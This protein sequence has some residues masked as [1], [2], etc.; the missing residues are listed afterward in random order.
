MA[1]PD[2]L[3]MSLDAKALKF[4]SEFLGNRA[5]RQIIVFYSMMAENTEFERNYWDN[6]QF[7]TFINTKVFQ[8]ALA[9]V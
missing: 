2:I 4:V 1:T 7:R 6:E 8:Q 5:P 3:Q 9:K